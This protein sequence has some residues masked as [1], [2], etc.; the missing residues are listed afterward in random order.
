MAP[1]FPKLLFLAALLPIVAG[2]QAAPPPPQLSPQS[3]Y[4][5]VVR[6]LEITRR[7]VANWSNSETAALALAIEQASEQCAART[8]EQFSGDPLIAFARLCSLGQ[9]W[10]A[11]GAAATSYIASEGPKPQLAQAYAFQVDAALH[12]N[13]P[14]AILASSL[15]MLHAVPYDALVDETSGSALHYLQLVFTPDALTLYADREPLILTQISKTMRPAGSI[16][17]EN[18]PSA[19][20][21]DSAVP[22]H[23]LY[24]GGIA[25]AALEQFA[26]D[27]HA[28]TKIVT[29]LD[30]ALPS[31]LQPDDFIPIDQIRRQYALLGTPLPR[32][33]LTLVALL[34]PGDAAY[35]YQLRELNRSAAIPRLVRPVRSHGPADSPHPLPRQRERRPSL[36]PPRATCAL[37]ARSPWL[38]A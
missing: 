2:G 16:P 3:A 20:P 9:Q 11:V 10:P 24:A 7:S 15:A 38:L 31:P 25:Y 30:A 21:A 34:R 35:Q 4:D 26:G 8:P 1:S 23:T 12:T 22:I 27:P 18:V 5:Q 14:K 6:P 17:S 32:I 13:D 33:P 36:R 19:A 28:A 37:R 29:D